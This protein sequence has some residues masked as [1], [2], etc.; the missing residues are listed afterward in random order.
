MDVLANRT[1]PVDTHETWNVV[2]STKLQCFKDCPRRYFYEYVLGW[3]P[4]RPNNHLHFGSAVHIA[5]EHILLNGYGTGS[6]SDA[7]MKFYHYYRTVFG[8]ETDDIFMPKN[9]D[10]F[11]LMLSEYVTRY[12]NDLSKYEVVVL[13]GDPLVEISGVVSVDG[14]YNL[15][16]KMDSV[17]RRLSDGKIFSLEHKTK[18][19]YFSNQWRMEFPLGT[20]VGTYTHALY[21]IFNPDEVL[22]VTI[23]GMSFKKTKKPSFEFERLPIRKT[24]E[25]M[26]AWQVHTVS[27]LRWMEKEFY[28]LECS[29]EDEDVLSAFPM[30]ERSCNKYFGC[31]YHDFCLAWPNPLKQSYEPPM[32]FIVDR[33]DPRASEDDTHPNFTL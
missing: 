33:W 23:N 15:Y 32:G 9:P 6:V 19:G 7:F 28:N 4:D 11:L 5:M 18:G 12:A 21:C 22:G 29:S 16:F 14:Y 31:P 10:R 17:L 27:W 26:Q 24:R 8:E 1:Y 30:N 20:Q 13:N 25:Q 3:R 2:D